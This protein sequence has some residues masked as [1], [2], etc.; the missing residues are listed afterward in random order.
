MQSWME[1]STMPLGADQ[2]Y[3]S[4]PSLEFVRVF[5]MATY[6]LM[7]QKH[8]V[9]AIVS[10]SFYAIEILKRSPHGM[11]LAG[12]GTF[13]PQLFVDHMTSWMWG[14]VH[15]VNLPDEENLYRTIL[16]AEPKTDSSAYIT[17][18][19]KELS[20]KGCNLEI[21]ITLKKGFN[22][23][24]R[25]KQRET[26]PIRAVGKFDPPSMNPLDMIRILKSTG[27]QVDTLFPFLGPRAAAWQRFSDIFK[28]F[29]MQ[30]WSD[31]CLQ[32][33]RSQM[34]EPKWLWPMAHLVLI[35]AHWG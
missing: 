26:I 7:T 14:E 27:W 5:N 32:M 29:N 8:P 15:P 28:R 20:I 4:R 24:R 35:R 31:R 10:S 19:L 22:L 34:R 33:K 16:W 30:Y 12:T 3:W 18:R 11:A 13:K 1:I 23:S 9:L 2:L 6:A 17:R 21:I 25:H